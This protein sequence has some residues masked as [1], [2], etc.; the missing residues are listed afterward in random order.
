MSKSRPRKPGRIA[1]SKLKHRV[2]KKKD[3]C[4]A[5]KAI[6]KIEID[7]L[8]TA[9]GIVG[10]VL[11]HFGAGVAVAREA[12]SPGSTAQ[13]FATPSDIAIFTDLLL[14]STVTNLATLNWETQPT[15]R[16]FVCSRA[17]DHGKLAYQTQLGPLTFAVI[18]DTLRVIQ[19]ICPPG[20]AGG[21]K[22]CAF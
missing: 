15:T 1:A 18:L 8:R 6:H 17:F 20:G 5:I 21:G 2:V 14:K 19:E 12:S 4:A 11:V 10:Q 3:P 13:I 22:V 16:N 9:A 7:D